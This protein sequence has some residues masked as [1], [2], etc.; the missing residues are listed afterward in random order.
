METEFVLVFDFELLVGF[1]FQMLV[2]TQGLVEIY[3]VY[4]S[5]FGL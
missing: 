5:Y 3:V 4:L 1:E 2:G